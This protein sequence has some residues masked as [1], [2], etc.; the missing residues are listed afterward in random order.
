M[1]IF[2]GAWFGRKLP[3]PSDR[4]GSVA[5]S[6][7]AKGTEGDGTGLRAES[8]VPAIPSVDFASSGDVS[9]VAK[10]K[11][12]SGRPGKAERSAA[13]AV[14]GDGDMSLAEPSVP[15]KEETSN[16]YVPIEEGLDA[17]IVDIAGGD[18]LAVD[19][20]ASLLAESE[21]ISVIT[22]EDMDDQLRRQAT[23]KKII[24]HL[25]NN[26]VNRYGD[27]IRVKLQEKLESIRQGQENAE[28]KILQS[29]ISSIVDL[30]QQGEQ[31]ILSNEAKKKVALD[32]KSRDRLDMV[33]ARLGS[34]IQTERAKIESLEEEIQQL[35]HGE[36]E[37]L[38]A[39]LVAIETR[40][41]KSVADRLARYRAILESIEK[42]PTFVQY[43]AD[44]KEAEDKRARDDAQRVQREKAVLEQKER[45]ARIAS[46]NAMADRLERNAGLVI[47]RCQR[48]ADRLTAFLQKLGKNNVNI[49]ER[50]TRYWTAVDREVQEKKEPTP[51]K[52]QERTGTMGESSEHILEE[53]KG[54][55][56]EAIKNG[57]FGL[58]DLATLL[59]HGEEMQ[60]IGALGNL[61]DPRTEEDIRLGERFDSP[62]SIEQK[63]PGLT[64]LGEALAK[65]GKVQKSSLPVSQGEDISREP[66]AM[67]ARYADIRAKVRRAKRSFS[68]MEKVFGEVYV[69]KVREGFKDPKT[70]KWHPPRFEYAGPI[71]NVILAAQGQGKDKK[72]QK[73]SSVSSEV[74]K[75]PPV[76]T[77]V[78]T[79]TTP[80]APL[81]PSAQKAGASHGQK[82]GKDKG[83]KGPRGGGGNQGGS[84]GAGRQESGRRE[85]E[86]QS[87]REKIPQSRRE[88]SRARES[89]LTSGID[90][91]A[92][93]GGEEV[94]KRTRQYVLPEGRTVY[95]MEIPLAHKQ[96]G[97]IGFSI[98]RPND[99][100][101][102]WGV[103][104]LGKDNL[105][106]I[107]QGTNARLVV[108]KI[109][110]EEELRNT[111]LSDAQS[112]LDVLNARRVA[113]EEKTRVQ[114]GLDVAGTGVVYTSGGAEEVVV[115]GVS[116]D[117]EDLGGVI[118]DFS[119]LVPVEIALEPGTGKVLPV[120]GEQEEVGSTEEPVDAEDS[121]WLQYAG[122]E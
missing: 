102:F 20:L 89:A 22:R 69:R 91:T 110:S 92:L 8:V 93:Q 4:A 73:S 31:A 2:D 66:S 46:L 81:P 53:I 42:D 121:P 80:M 104:I 78:A 28:V 112:I 86:V 12:G 19:D 39:Q 57:K 98:V 44:L 15:A 18:S 96:K 77:G 68:F 58:G 99:K 43:V 7:K 97:F 35:I 45:E 100:R 10:P 109:F 79:E 37:S 106:L 105:Q 26:G 116:D 47:S 115:E 51:K 83:K 114:N 70:G 52:Q 76:A 38:N 61:R 36:L 29:R 11:R 33:N 1:G 94:A 108:G 21:T 16:G 113:H 84:G 65:A 87:K 111:L 17:P 9:H 48:S 56:K 41:Q 101:D 120:P 59:P 34:A 85:E 50:M 63:V 14:R 30:I 13:L 49:G 27:Q 32:Q 74:P 3:A 107:D 88:I 62:I 72:A 24:S 5:S 23:A 90:F 6:K 60:V 119:T 67:K 95:K 40:A 103:R 82:S 118:N 54:M 71:V 25:E 64:A 117:E 55:L 75:T 122:K